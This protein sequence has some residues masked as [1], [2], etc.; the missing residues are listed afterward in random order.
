MKFRLQA[1]IIFQWMSFY[2][3]GMAKN[4]TQSAHAYTGQMIHHD[5][6]TNIQLTHTS[7]DLEQASIT[8]LSTFMNAEA[9]WDSFGMGFRQGLD[10]GCREN[11]IF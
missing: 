3:A 11:V 1:S 7:T 10:A 5:S 2:I 4:Y 6:V 8:I 9:V